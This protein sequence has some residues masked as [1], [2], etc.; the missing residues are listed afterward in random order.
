[1]PI[2]NWKLTIF[3]IFPTHT[4]KPLS[5]NLAAIE[6]NNRSWNCFNPRQLEWM[7]L[8]IKIKLAGTPWKQGLKCAQHVSIQA[9]DILMMKHAAGINNYIYNK[10]SACTIKNRNIKVIVLWVGW[11]PRNFKFLICS[12]TTISGENI[13]RVIPG[14]FMWIPK[15]ALNMNCE[16]F[17]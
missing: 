14:I 9:S 12:K 2:K 1:M 11:I 7:Y 15:F 6:F 8:R 10:Y 17:Q 16:F 5:T 4:C 13:M 3:Q